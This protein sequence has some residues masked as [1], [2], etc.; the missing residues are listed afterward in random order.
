VID[1]D[2]GQDLWAGKSIGRK[3]WPLGPLSVQNITQQGY[4]LLRWTFIMGTVCVHFK[5]LGNFVFVCMLD[6]ESNVNLHPLDSPFSV[7]G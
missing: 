5:C 3:F 7:C 1:G 4:A 6:D 2:F